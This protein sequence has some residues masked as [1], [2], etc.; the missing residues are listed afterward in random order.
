[1][2]KNDCEMSLEFDTRPILDAIAKNI[3]LNFL[4]EQSK[5]TDVEQV[6]QCSH[7]ILKSIGRTILESTESPRFL[8]HFARALGLH[9]MI[10]EDAA[11]DKAFKSLEVPDDLKDLFKSFLKDI[12]KRSEHASEKH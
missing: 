6:M 11:L 2:S 1:M 5:P 12:K 7:H 8:A 10:D 4:T 3:E 9:K